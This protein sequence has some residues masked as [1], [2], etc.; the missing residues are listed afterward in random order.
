MSTLTGQPSTS[1][2]SNWWCDTVRPTVD[3]T[4]EFM[5]DVEMAQSLMADVSERQTGRACPA[6]SPA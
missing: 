5:Q 1:E 4:V 2:Y 6:I 3:D